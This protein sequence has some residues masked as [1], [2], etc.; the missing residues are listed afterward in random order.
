MLGRTH[1]I[2]STA[3]HRPDGGR[4]WTAGFSRTRRRA[5]ST[6]SPRKW[7]NLRHIRPELTGIDT[8]NASANR[9]MLAINKAVG[10]R[11]VDSWI[12]RQRSR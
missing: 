10:F 3:D 8:F 11:P 9:H 5:T 7:T 4:I 1:L 6:L 12:Q 2:G